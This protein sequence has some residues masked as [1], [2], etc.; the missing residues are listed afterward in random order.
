M[1]YLIRTKNKTLQS[2]LTK[3]MGAFMPLRIFTSMT[4][5]CLANGISKSTVMEQIFT[6]WLSD[7]FTTE[8]ETI[9]YK[10]IAARLHE[11]YEELR[12]TRR[13]LAYSMFCDDS[14]KELSIKGLHYANIQNVIKEL[15]TIH[16]Q[17]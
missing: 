2:P 6:N 8:M 3:Y 14:R 1:A 5:Y 15:D 16:F 4:I 10:A 12:L 11:R 17:R 7:N 13:S 9:C